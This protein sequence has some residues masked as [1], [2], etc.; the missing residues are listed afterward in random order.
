MAQR[1]RELLL[2]ARGDT[3]LPP[4]PQSDGWD[5]APDRWTPIRELRV[6]HLWSID[7]PAEVVVCDPVLLPHKTVLPVPFVAGPHHVLTAFDPHARQGLGGQGAYLNVA[8]MIV[9]AGAT[10]VRWL[11]SLEPRVDDDLAVI[12]PMNTESIDVSEDPRA[13]A[14]SNLHGVRR[15]LTNRGLDA[16]VIESVSGM[17]LVS[18]F[19]GVDAE[20]RA[21]AVFVPID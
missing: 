10:V 9:R 1:D 15:V 6:E 20:G 8:V 16:V 11:P 4:R 5:A 17:P 13:P 3:T 18:L 12:A 2:A 21:A 19:L 7:L 14:S